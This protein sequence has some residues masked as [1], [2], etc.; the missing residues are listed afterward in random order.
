M[1][2]LL[3]ILALGL[4]LAAPAPVRA[5]NVLFVADGSNDAG[6][7]SALMADGHRVT[8]RSNDL[9]RF[10]G[11]TSF[12]DVAA[13]REYDAIFWSASGGASWIHTSELAFVTLRSYVEGG[14]RVMVVGADAAIA[15]PRVVD[16]LG[17]TDARSDSSSPG[18]IASIETSVTVG[19]VDIR[20]QV[21]RDGSSIKNC[22]TGLGED[23]DPIAASS[24]DASCA[25]WSLR[26]LGDGEVAWIGNGDSF[27]SHPSWVDTSSAYNAAL[28]NFAGGADTGSAEPGAPMIE[29]DGAYSAEE[30]A[31]VVITATVTD[32][33]GDPVIFSWDLNEDGSFG[34]NTGMPSYTIPAGT[35]DGNATVRVSI[36][37]SDGSNVATRTR[38]LRIRN[39]PPRVTSEP[40]T[41]T[42]VGANIRYRIATEEPAGALDPVVYEMVMGPEGATVTPEGVF[43][44]RPS[45]LDVTRA[46]RRIRVQ[47][48]LDDGD[49]GEVTHAWE[50]SVSP[51]HAPSA[52][53]A[54]Y[55]ANGIAIIERAP[56]LV[57]SNA[58]DEDVIDAMTYRFELDDEETFSDPLLARGERIEESPG[59]TAF[60]LSEPLPYGRYYWR[61]W[62]NDGTADSEPALTDFW[63]VPDPD[64]DAGP[65]AADGAIRADAGASPGPGGGRGCTCGA[66]GRGTGSP[67]ALALF[68][69]LF[70]TIRRAYTR[71]AP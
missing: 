32:A 8:M 59:F 16:F 2:R 22:L 68:L 50:M 56:R 69:A 43:T 23:T 64:A 5:A 27:G 62:A 66:P 47:I 61:A 71:R 9:D 63:V 1:L 57:V 67:S 37:A 25:Q 12:T 58:S 48:R 19:A 18:S 4:A 38:S 35:S 26:R 6:I 40:P 34:E 41:E 42:S 3:P 10:G 52:I 21:A 29:F 39:V 15:D 11:N 60:Q 30:G 7:A 49:G 36:E 45:E 65:A 24:F 31:E 44:W 53:T 55:P 54:L 70:L 46:G 51:N 17:A 14:G 33:E 20:G 28:R 13:L